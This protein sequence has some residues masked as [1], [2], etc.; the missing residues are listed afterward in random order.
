MK[1]N[2]ERKIN[3]KALKSLKK[4]FKYSFILFEIYFK[5]AELMNLSDG[6]TFV[7]FI[8]IAT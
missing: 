6:K 7:L 2:C 8:I 3:I 1:M 5:S 4:V